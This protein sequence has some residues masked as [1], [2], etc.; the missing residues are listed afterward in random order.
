MSPPAPSS[1]E[2]HSRPVRFASEEVGHFNRRFGVRLADESQVEAVLYRGDTLCVSCQVGC[3]VRCPFCASGANGLGRNL[4]LDELLGQLEGV[5]ERG[6]SVARVTVSGVGE[7]LHNH[8]T[9]AAFLERCRARKVRMSLTTSGGPLKRLREWLHLPH[10]GLTLS[11]HA[12]TEATRKETVPNGPALGPLFETLGD[13]LPRMTQR[14]K[15]KLALAYLMIAGRTDGED[16][17][18]AFAARVRP[19]GVDVHLYAYNPVPTSADRPVSRRAYEAAYDRL[20]QAGLSVRMS[21]QARIEAN[22]GCG[23]LVA[24][25]PSRGPGRATGTAPA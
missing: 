3:A 2:A 15:R 10:N 4:T 13:E 16:E 14:R 21:S 18:D 7:P 25:R 11:I 9:V 17:L 6:H 5:I 1:D 19:L 12:G 23:T 20:V 8:A 24:I 22:G